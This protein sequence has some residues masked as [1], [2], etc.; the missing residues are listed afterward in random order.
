MD[1]GAVGALFARMMLAFSPTR[2]VPVR[3]RPRATTIATIALVAPLTI[4]AIWIGA[5]AALMPGCA[6]CHLTD[7]FGSETSAGA[8]ASV[9]CA[10]C[11]GGTTA[12][13]RV[14]FGTS[15]VLGM[16]LP[17]VGVDPT[18]ADVPS[19][20]CTSCHEAVL[21]GLV[22]SGGLRIKHEIC[23]Q[24][25]ACTDCHSPTA[26][27]A[28]L[29][30]P[31]TTAMD[32]CFE[33]HATAGITT[34]CDACHAG[35]LPSERI[36]SG[37]FVVTHG[38]DYLKTHGMGRMTTCSACHEQDRCARC[39]GAGV[40]HGVK[41]VQQHASQ[42]ASSAAKCSGCHVEAFCSDCHAYPMPH[43]AEFTPQH[44][45]IVE[46][47]GRD[48]CLTCHVESDCVR[49]HV[50]HVHPTTLNQLRGLGVLGEGGDV[51]E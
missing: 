38:P 51:D 3:K 20:R 18:L 13:S 33:C 26:H 28:A 10:K 11:H 31:R 36:K 45:D 22:E 47:D 42:A 44:A 17:L 35:R 30:W 1:S 27:G 40:P 50:K 19:A 29:S 14:R 32:P 25:Q 16:Y 37:P 4:L 24:G 48:G 6:G 49:C 7:E 39:H 34:A 5:D 12:M 15:Q 46:K 23:A 21:A 43:P 41:F 2:K 9:A 8:H